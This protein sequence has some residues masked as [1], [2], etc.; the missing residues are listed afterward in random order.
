[1]AGIAAAL[2]LILMMAASPAVQGVQHIVG[3]DSH[4]TL[5]VNY[6]SWAATQKFN[7]GDTLC[8]FPHVSPQK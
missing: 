1:M 4:W 7:V 8:K 6:T 2:A 5:G 3:G